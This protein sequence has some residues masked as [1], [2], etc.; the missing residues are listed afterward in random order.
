MRSRLVMV[1]LAAALAACGSSGTDTAGGDTAGTE[2][3]EVTS[4]AAEGE[5]EGQQVA[6]VDFS[7]DPSELTVASGTDVVW[8]N[9][10]GAAHTVTFD[11][12]EDSGNLEGGAT[13][14]RTFAEAG[15]YPY[16]CAIHPT[17]TG[18]VTVE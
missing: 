2:A 1:A 6:I 13:Y 10:D 8:Q 4:A 18:T 17:M 3:A 9:E 16:A 11:D 14:A 12:G 5:G 7:F 15:D